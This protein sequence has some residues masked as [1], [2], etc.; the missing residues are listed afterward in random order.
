MFSWPC[1]VGQCVHVTDS[2]ERP[3]C[4]TLMFARCVCLF[5][6]HVT[7]HLWNSGRLCADM[8]ELLQATEHRDGSPE[9]KWQYC[10]VTSGK[11]KY[12]H[13]EVMWLTPWQS[14]KGESICTFGP[15]ESSEID[16]KLS[17]P[18][19]PPPAWTQSFSY[20]LL[21]T[22]LHGTEEHAIV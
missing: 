16:Q 5:T 12:A 7:I 22:R 8:P 20:V 2:T 11:G 6:E 14:R 9:G 18:P 3:R 13:C 21:M 15:S 4:R 19:P 17:P 10:A 1:A